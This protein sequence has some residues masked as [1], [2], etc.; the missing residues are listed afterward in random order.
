MKKL[1]VTARYKKKLNQLEKQI[2]YEKDIYWQKFINH[3]KVL[4]EY[5]YI[6]NDYPNEKGLIVGALRSENELFISEVINSGLLKD[7]NAY[8]L[9][10]VMCA[11]MTEDMRADLIS[12]IPI[13]KNV[14]IVLSKIKNIKKKLSIIQADN[15]IE[16]PIY[17]NSFY[18]PLIEQWML[19]DSDWG[20]LSSQVEI[21]EGDI[22]RSFK[23]TIDILRQLTI[24]NNVDPKIV[25]TA[26]EAIDLIL[27]EPINLD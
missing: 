25:E 6:K 20:T 26:R 17:I 11:L 2:R 5:G 15:N 3:K 4:E 7:L 9:A 13:S 8:E 14:R 21:G 10:S 23:R 16:T 12:R 27:K 24:I 1:E 19:P 18:S 22:V